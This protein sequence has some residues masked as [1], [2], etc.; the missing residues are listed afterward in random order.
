MTSTTKVAL[1]TG[2][3]S[4]LGKNVVRLL[5]E[6]G[7]KVACLDLMHSESDLEVI[8]DVSQS[9]HASDVV[10]KTISR[11]GRIDAVVSC[12]GVAL[13]K[14]KSTH[15]TDESDWDRCMNVNLRGSF[16]ISKYAL[17]YLIDSKGSL[18]FIGS[19]A[20][21]HPQPGSA[22]YSS[23]KAGVIALSRSIALEYGPLG[24]RSNCISPGYMNTEM[25]S[26]VRANHHLNEKVT[27]QIP[28][29]HMA[30][31]SEIAGVVLFLLSME[32]RFM[33]GA[34]LIVDG[35]NCLTSYADLNDVR[36]M[37]KISPPAD[38]K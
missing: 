4:G 17:P 16:L 20:G 36:K 34:N 23:S 1:V 9:T 6:K 28:L 19:V 29:G 2:G 27:D 32:S 37:W 21:M 26:R 15:N 22:G 3:S 24:V 13:N 10:E 38:I 31:T 33:T 11:F 12:A 25:T 30:E 7:Y 5:Q 8:G 35:G 14:F 18:V